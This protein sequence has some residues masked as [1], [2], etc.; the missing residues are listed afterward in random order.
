MQDGAETYRYLTSY[1][2]P[3]QFVEEYSDCQT[4]TEPGQMYS[5]LKPGTPML[6]VV[7]T[8]PVVGAAFVDVKLV[9]DESL[10]VL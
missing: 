9:H 1:H 5:K 2:G 6:S 7:Q 10:Y 3:E 4:K 8:P